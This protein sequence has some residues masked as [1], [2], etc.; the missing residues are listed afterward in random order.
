MLKQVNPHLPNDIHILIVKFRNDISL[1]EIPLLRGAILNAL[2]GDADVLFHN[3]IGES[4]RYSYPLIQYKRIQGKAAVVCLKEGTEIIGQFFSKGMFAFKL[5]D[6]YLKM[7]IE[8]VIPKKYLIQSWDSMFK[9]RI[10]RWLP[11]NSD[12][13]RRYQALEGI[14]EKISFL[15]NI[16]IANLLSFAKG[17][18][19]HIDKNIQCKLTSMH[20]PFLIRSKGVKLMAFDIEF[21]TNISLPDYIGIGKNASI[22]FGVIT[23]VLNEKN[24]DK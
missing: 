23:H 12:N 19:I 16:L 8:S 18:E 6:R 22:G 14:S 5:G 2:N 9:Y 7:E 15:E 17:V 1:S 13:Y 3:H 24:N 4:F 21:I 20:E 11:L 10:R